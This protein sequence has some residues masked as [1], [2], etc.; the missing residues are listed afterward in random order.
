MPETT[1]ETDFSLI[2]GEISGF[3][4]K[5]LTPND[6]G[7]LQRLY[8]KCPDYFEIVEGRPAL[9]GAA[10]EDIT[11]CAPFKNIKDKF[12]YGI[13]DGQNRL[14]GIF[15]GFKDYPQTGTWWIGLFMLA[16]EARG[17]NV[18]RAIIKKFEESA[19]AGS[20]RK[21]KLGIVEDNAPAFAFWKK[22]GFEFSSKTEPKIF[23]LK[24][25]PVHI[26]EKTLK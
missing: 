23:G 13:F 4:A 9:P 3:C 1:K 18:G 24:T 16:P 14:T 25:Q 21:I 7:I 15:E 26:Y 10:A 6:S 2:C 22:C 20:A 12:L 5:P 19:F 11:A 8:E 17:K